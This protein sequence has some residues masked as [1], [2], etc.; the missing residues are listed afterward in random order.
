MARDSSPCGAVLDRDRPLLISHPERHYR[1]GADAPPIV[2]AL[3]IPFHHEGKPVGTVW[4][5]AHDETRR[6][7]AEDQRLMTRLSR[8]AAS[9]TLGPTPSPGRATRRYA[10]VTA[11]RPPCAGPRTRPRPR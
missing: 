5:I 10:F 3:L 1:Y 4:V 9:T 7:D 11:G 6:F 2:E 8:F